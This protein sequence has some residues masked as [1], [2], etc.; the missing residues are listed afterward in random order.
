MPGGKG[1]G[2]IMNKNVL[3]AHSA[4]ERQRLFAP[5]AQH[6][7]PERELLGLCAR[8]LDAS[9]NGVFIT[10][11]SGPG[12]HPIVYANIALERMTGYC[13]GELLGSDLRLLFGAD[14]DQPYL[15]QL[16]E[17]M[18]AGIATQIVVRNYTKSGKCFWNEIAMAP[19]YDDDGELSHFIHS[20]SDVTERIKHLSELERQTY[21]DPLTGLANRHLL[22]ERL[23]HSLAL[24][25]RHDRTMA[26]IVVGLDRFKTINDS[27]GHAVGDQLLKEVAGQILTCVRDVDTVARVGGDEF[28]LILAEVESDN[29]AMAAIGRIFASVSR[30]YLIA[31]QELHVACSIGAS[32]FPRD[33]QDAATLLRNADA[34]M[35]RAKDGGRSR[36]QFFERDIN[37]RLSQRLSLENGLRHAV[38]RGELELDYQPQIALASG[39]VVGVEALLRW[40]HPQ[41]GRVPPSSF[42]GIAEETGL[43]VPIG[44]WVLQAACAQARAWRDAGLPPLR[45]AVNLSARQFRHKGLADSIRNAM[46]ANRLE[47]GA[48]ELEITESMAMVDPEET[49]CLLREFKAQGLRIALDDFGTG[50]S[51]LSY[52]KRFPIDV[53]KIDQSFVAGIASDRSD[54][55]IARTVIGL[56]RSLWLQTIAEGVETLEQADLLHR[57]TCDEAQGFHFSVPLAP[58]AVTEM[59]Q[60]GRKF[61]RP[62]PNRRFSASPG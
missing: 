37:A 12:D 28:V 19:V 54:A 53:L 4:G 47:A 58:Q 10:K 29:D 30:E 61:L 50:F 7:R 32:L 2:D 48:L 23:A 22:N 16:G 35:H 55:A 15:E 46:Q 56:A 31:E 9:N 42:I 20:C 17:A 57:W 60:R 51:S 40:R 44:E 27:L 26:V 41:L 6:P 3:G 21:H 45:V 34:A 1:N 52:I 43:I 24:A 62:T 39:A 36:F 5:Q 49:I 38:E 11:V 8:A 14:L 13:A 25:G 33:G 18:L 59:L